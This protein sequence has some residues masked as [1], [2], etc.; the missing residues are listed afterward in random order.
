MTLH[1]TQG[2]YATALNSA[3]RDQ[4]ILREGPLGIEPLGVAA[5]AVAPRHLGN[6]RRAVFVRAFRPDGFILPE[7]YGESRAGN[8]DVLIARRAQVHF[9]ALE[10]G[11]VAR[12]V[13]KR[14]KIEIRRQ[15]RD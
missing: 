4:Q 7:R 10:I 14:G 1:V 5:K 11:V 6:V 9:D 13:A 15:V 3:F 12:L 2:R 8:G